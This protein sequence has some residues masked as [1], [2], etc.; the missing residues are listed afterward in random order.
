M[1]QSDLT[2]RLNQA[3]NLVNAGRRAEARE[4][5]LDLSKQYPQLEQ[6]WMWL[7]TATDDTKDRAKYLRQVLLI[8]PYNDKARSALSRLTGETVTPAGPSRRATA[9]NSASFSTR[10]LES[11]LIAILGLIVIV[12]IIL[13]VSM[14]VPTLLAPHP[15]ATVTPT[16]SATVN[17]QFSL[18][19][20]ITPGGPTLTPYTPPPLP[21][22]WTASPTE[23]ATA[24]FTPSNT[25]TPSVTFTISP[26]FVK[27]TRIPTITPGGPTFTEV[28]PTEKPTTPTP[29]TAAPSL[30]PPATI[31]PT[32]PK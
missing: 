24:T 28:P 31:A 1:S 22:T 15:T 17:L 23:R 11:W 4:I 32:Q 13:A 2:T 12:L 27:V 10:R 14:T 26:T 6:V 25:F 3:I 18:T 5:L 7:A 30:A 19:P 8:N 29:L 21:P 20:S 16:A 9:S